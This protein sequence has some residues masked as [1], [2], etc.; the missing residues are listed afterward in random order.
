MVSRR[1]AGGARIGAPASQV[2]GWRRGLVSAA[3]LAVGS[4]LGVD[5]ARSSPGEVSASPEPSARAL[6]AADPDRFPVARGM[7]EVRG[8]PAPREVVRA[9]PRP[10]VA[11]QTPAFAVRAETQPW[12]P[13]IVR[14]LHA[15]GALP[16]IR[17]D[18]PLTPRD[19]RGFVSPEGEVLTAA[20]VVEGAARVCLGAPSST[21]CGQRAV[22]LAED[23]AR[24]V[25][26]LRPVTRSAPVAEAAPWEPPAAELPVWVHGQGEQP[27]VQRGA[28]RAAVRRDLRGAPVSL[29]S[30][31]LQI[32]VGYSG[33]PVY[34]PRGGVVGMVVA[35]DDPDGDRRGDALLV[36]APIV[37]PTEPPEPEDDG[38]EVG[39]A[40]DLT[41]REI[42]FEA[43]EGGL[44][45]VG[46]PAQ[47]E[48][49]GLRL[50]DVV[51]AFGE[52]PAGRSPP[53][54]GSAVVVRGPGVVAVV[55]EVEDPIAPTP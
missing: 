18:A 26:W 5:D 6:D 33:A 38:L 32:R 1:A 25:A 42:T 47:A 22:I 3:V 30:S 14:W 15:A 24:D 35:G 12:H 39:P 17:K 2:L 4:A 23:R 9:A 51:T 49:L 7:D 43:V 29:W 53:P 21:E 46:L 28:L 50:G 55:A 11:G 36:P 20:H 52:V 19:G 10:A 31:D 27:A 37:A 44:R 34:G 13:A 45:V 41:W 16:P 40:P 54:A 48:V 8:E